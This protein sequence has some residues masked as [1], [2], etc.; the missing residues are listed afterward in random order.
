VEKDR[1][2]AAEPPVRDETAGSGPTPTACRSLPA[3]GGLRG[4]VDPPGPRTG[5]GPDRR[6][7]E[8]LLPGAVPPPQE[9]AP[10]TGAGRDAAPRRHCG[11]CL[12]R[13]TVAGAVT[14]NQLTTVKIAIL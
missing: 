8:A 5:G 6:A 9:T 3:P 12:D 2:V 13:L 7:Y 11:D 4:R 10:G 1:G 14:G